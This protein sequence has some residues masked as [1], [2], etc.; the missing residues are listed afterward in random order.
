M[1]PSEVYQ[2]AAYYE[3]AMGF[4]NIPRQIALL[5]A[6][7]RA[8]SAIPVRRVLDVCCGPSPQLRE[9]ARRGY[10]GVGLDASPP[11]LAYLHAR[12]AEEQVR[13]ETICADMRDFALPAPVDVC[14]ILLGTIP[15]VGS[16]QGMLDH[17]ACVARALRPGGLYLIENLLM[18]WVSA[19]VG[20]RQDWVMTRDGITVTTHYQ[21]DVLDPLAQTARHTLEFAVDDHGQS[22]RL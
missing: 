15:Y 17:L 7:I 12:A 13:V 6:Y 1:T 21:L 3:I 5:E 16:R 18:D 9:F 8:Y 19:V 2:H 20:N 10:L 22:V 4:V 11:M 14:Y